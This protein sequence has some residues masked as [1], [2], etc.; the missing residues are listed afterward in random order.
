MKKYL[1]TG[2]AGFIG[3]HLCDYLLDRGHKVVVVDNFNAYYDVEIKE[4]N[5]GSNLDNPNYK[6]YRGD[7]RDIDFLKKIF[8]DEK[9]DAVINLA[10]MAG[11]RPS[12][13]NPMLYEEV[14]IRGL[15]NLLEL[16]KANGINKFIQASSSSVYG[17]NK[18][19]PFKE[20]AVVDFAISP[21]AATKKSGEVMGHVYHYLYNIDMIQLR[22]FTVYGPRQRP[23][24]A[25]HKFTGMITAGEA[26]PFYGDGT[27]QR[28]YTY[29]DDIIDGIVKS[30]RYL[31]NNDN[32]YEIFNLGESHTISLKEMVGTIEEELGIEAKINRQPMQPGDV[33]KTYADISKA[34]EILGYN[35]KTEFKDG[36]R[37]F[38]QWYREN[39][40]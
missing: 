14:N 11:I 31:E 3:S 27:T 29:I 25:I 5:V 23:D 1:V 37:K 24:L 8:Q 28:D 20:T 18:K 7:I 2:G 9:I 13:E 12:L 4:R 15:M 10:A 33:E 39:N 19:V 35:P 22:F 26:I 38:V 32:V 21:Y 36:I 30:I 17:N 40:S 6:L 34:K 16:S